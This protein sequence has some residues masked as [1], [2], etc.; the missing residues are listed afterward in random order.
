MTNPF[1]KLSQRSVRI[2]YTLI[3]LVVLS[4]CLFNFSVQMFE[5]VTGNDQCRWVDKDST[6]LLIKDIVRNGV[7]EHAGIKDGD[8]LLKINGRHFK[9]ANDA[10]SMINKLAGS[11]TEYTIERNGAQFNVRILILKYINLGYLSQFLFGLGFLLVGYV[12]VIVKP[13][14][15]IQRMFA[16][17]CICSMLFFGFAAF[18]LD[19]R[20]DPTWRFAVLGVSFVIISI[21]APPP[22][23]RF[24]LFFPAKR[25][26]SES[27]GFA[28]LLYSV[29]LLL[30]VGLTLNSLSRERPWLS[31]VFFFTRYAFFFSGF[32]VFIQSYFHF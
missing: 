5:R 27:R 13:Q 9:N 1:S 15:K 14:G 16:R 22:L 30:I 18:N 20:N 26:W 3:T 32:V 29:S 21:L 7:S 6:K 17:Y 25:K 24:F 10:Q 8:V 12:V 2:L 31:L 11:Y 19:P 23:V 4:L 28:I